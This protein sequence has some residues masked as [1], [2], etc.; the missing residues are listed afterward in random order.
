MHFLQNLM[1][2]FPDSGEVL[3]TSGWSS[4]MYFCLFNMIP[5]GFCQNIVPVKKKLGIHFQIYW[6]FPDSGEGLEISSWTSLMYF[7]LFIQN[8]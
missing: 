2:I 4:L 8:T 3:E 5:K 6:K 1:D 7:S